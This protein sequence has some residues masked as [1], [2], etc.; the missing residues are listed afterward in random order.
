MITPRSFPL[1]L[2]PVV[3]IVSEVIAPS[4]T[5]DGRE[6]LAA[7]A[8]DLT[9]LR[10]WVWLGLLAAALLVPAVMAMLALAPDRGRRTAMV[11]AAAAT[12]GV[13]GYAAHQ[14]LFMPLPTLLHG[15]RTEMAALYERQ[16]QTGE[17]GILIFLVFLV[18]LFLGLLLLG[19][20]AYRAGRAPLWPALVLGA[21]FVPGFLPVPFDAGLVSFVLLLVGLWA[22]GVAV[23]RDAD[24]TDRLAQMSR[25]ASMLAPSKL[26]RSARSS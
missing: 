2:A 15:D 17:S 25:K 6:S 5:D 7:V 20:A 13:V 11:G 4:L 9:A 23:C 18:P 1:F 26:S 22:Y 24:A 10:A 21:A 16:S 3:V 12:V 19:V 14:A 8:G